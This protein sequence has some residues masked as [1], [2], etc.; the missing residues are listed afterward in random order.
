[1]QTISHFAPISI[2]FIASSQQ[3][4]TAWATTLSGFFRFFSH[5]IG[6]PSG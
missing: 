2:E 3:G 5:N 1:M 4:I 6:R